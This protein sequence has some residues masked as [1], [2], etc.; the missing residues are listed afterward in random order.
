MDDIIEKLVKKRVSEVLSQVRSP[1][2]TFQALIS[3]IYHEKADTIT[4]DNQT[5]PK[6]NG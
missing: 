2:E 1:T 6:S 4:G 5:E 3:D